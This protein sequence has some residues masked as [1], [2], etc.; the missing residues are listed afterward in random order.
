MQQGYLLNIP[1]L[2]IQ[3]GECTVE[4]KGFYRTPDLKRVEIEQ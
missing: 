2:C 3:A 4:V 1:L